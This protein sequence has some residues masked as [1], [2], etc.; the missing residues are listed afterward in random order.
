MKLR[1]PP[2]NE[3]TGGI[4][5]QLDCKYG[6]DCIDFAA[7]S[8]GPPWRAQSVNIPITD[9]AAASRL[10]IALDRMIRGNC[11]P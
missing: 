6:S 2:Q 4:Q 7:G 9:R 10:S 8:A 1:N 3:C 5:L 11:E